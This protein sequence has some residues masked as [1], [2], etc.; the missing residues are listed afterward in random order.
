MILINMEISF[1]PGF[2]TLRR[3]LTFQ[4]CYILILEK[5]KRAE[6]KSKSLTGSTLPSLGHSKSQWLLF[7]SE[8]KK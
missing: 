4:N 6:R 2:P 3:I 7:S 1:P 5:A 8:I